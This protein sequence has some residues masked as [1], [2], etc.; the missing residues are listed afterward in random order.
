MSIDFRANKSDDSDLYESQDSVFTTKIVKKKSI[1]TKQRFLNMVMLVVLLMA[2]ALSG[3]FYYKLHNLQKSTQ[4]VAK[5]EAKDLLGKIAR[6]Y[7]IPTGEE[8]TVATVSDPEKL[9]DQAF[10]SGAAKDD[11]VLIFTNA[12]KAVLYRPSID[13]I[14]EVAPINKPKNETPPA[15]EKSTGPLKDKTF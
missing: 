11:K 7:L 13:K 2:I 3:Y 1:M 15:P 10:F 5:K 12:G 9:K 6:L 8:P 4:E 14:I